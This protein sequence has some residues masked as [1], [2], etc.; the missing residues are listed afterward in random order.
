MKQLDPHSVFQFFDK[1][2]VQIHKEHGQED[3][4]DNPSFWLGMVVRGVDN[5]HLMDK[6]QARRYGERYTDLAPRIKYKFYAKLVEH[7]KRI[8]I[9][10]HPKLY[11]DA[12]AVG[13]RNVLNALDH[14]RRYFEGF[15]EYE[16]CATIKLYIDTVYESDEPLFEF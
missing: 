2:D 1:D 4:F 10:K 11:S 12:K 7:L 6:V 3:V 15:E 5:Y 8:D 9:T 14:L 13:F 16:R